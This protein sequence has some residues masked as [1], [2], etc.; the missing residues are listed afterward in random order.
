MLIFDGPLQTPRYPWGPR[1]A[2]DQKVAYNQKQPA[3]DFRGGALLY[4][5][6]K[7]Q[8][9][10]WPPGQPSRLGPW[11]IPIPTC[12]LPRWPDSEK[13]WHNPPAPKPPEQ[14]DLAKPAFLGSGPDPKGCG[15]QVTH[16]KIICKEIC[17]F[18]K[19]R[20]NPFYGLK[21]TALFWSDRRT[22]TQTPRRTDKNKS[23]QYHYGI[24]RQNDVWCS[25]SSLV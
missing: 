23:S 7:I 25:P 24:L 9:F 8:N 16:P 17:G 4:K 6:S 10:D 19:F 18:W 14:I 20:A 13:V 2:L 3:A 21:V 22:G 15:V 11:A 1:G 12:C 5:M